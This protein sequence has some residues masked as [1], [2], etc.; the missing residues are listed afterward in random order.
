MLAPA[1][2]A[3]LSTAASLLRTR[4]EWMHDCSNLFQAKRPY[5]SRPEER[6]GYFH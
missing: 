6:K 4:L 2:S 5:P 1:D 3:F